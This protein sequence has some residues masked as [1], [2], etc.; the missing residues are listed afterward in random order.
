MPS[1][2]PKPGKQGKLIANPTAQKLKPIP[3]ALTVL[4][5][6][7]ATVSIVVFIVI[8]AAILFAFSQL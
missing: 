3:R 8:I 7:N 4:L 6:V 2:N 5:R 1:P